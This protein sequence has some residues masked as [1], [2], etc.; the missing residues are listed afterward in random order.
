MIDSFEGES[1]I[2][3]ATNHHHVLDPAIWRRFDEVVLYKNPTPVDC[4]KLLDLFLKPIPKN[5]FQLESIAT[6]MKDLAP[7]EIKMVAHE[8]M[9]KSILEGR[10]KLSKSD[11]EVATKRFID[12]KSIKSSREG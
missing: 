12:R 1:L 2:F 3:A 10:S 5:D 8:A 7:S 4:L 11:M 6:K 9:K